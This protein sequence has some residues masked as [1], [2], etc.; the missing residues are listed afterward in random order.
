MAVNKKQTIL[1]ISLFVLLFICLG[2]LGY[3]YRDTLFNSVTIKSVNNN[4][5]DDLETNLGV[6]YLLEVDDVNES[7]TL[8]VQFLNSTKPEYKIIKK[9]KKLF[10]DDDLIALSQEKLPFYVA[11]KKEEKK[12]S[13]E[14]KD[15]KTVNEKVVKEFT[16]K[17]PSYLQAEVDGIAIFKPYQRY[18]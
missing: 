3:I 5:Q 8:G 16:N 4:Q 1:I 15:S 6:L 9:E 17:L 11:I 2:L 12:Y 14:S 18:W 13:I 7:I 10:N